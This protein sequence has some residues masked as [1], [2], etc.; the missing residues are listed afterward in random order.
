[1]KRTEN[2]IELVLRFLDYLTLTRGYTAC[3]VR[4]YRNAWKAVYKY[5][6]G[7]RGI[8]PTALDVEDL[9]Q[10]FVH[11]FLNYLEQKRA[12]KTTSRNNR[13]AVIQSFFRFLAETDP[14]AYAQQAAHIL[15][16]R[17]KRAEKPQIDYLTFEEAAA[18]LAVPNPETWCGTRDR[19]L[20]TFMIQTGVRSEEVRRISMN[21]ITFGSTPQ[22]HIRFGKG[23]KRRVLPLKVETVVELQ[24]WLEI[25]D[26][27]SDGP[28]FLS[29]RR[30]TL[31][32]DALGLIVQSTMAELV[33]KHPSLAAKNITPHK[34]RHT[35]A[36][37][38]YEDGVSIETLSLWLG[39]ADVSTTMRYLQ[40]SLKIKLRAMNRTTFPAPPILGPGR[41]QA[42][43]QFV[44]SSADRELLKK[45]K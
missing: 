40:H 20:L 29:T 12:N 22:V 33:E 2:L 36:M 39:H 42:I 11:D 21:D 18:F 43:G 17:A 3:T 16:I 35:A 1:M 30:G 19:A 24:K 13:L 44:L 38:M 10:E 25:R 8:T 45:L 23:R 9:T 14:L 41:E 7:E 15:A 34:L 28:F 4:T 6:Q 26:E 27:G 5:A 32:D 37:M 31:S